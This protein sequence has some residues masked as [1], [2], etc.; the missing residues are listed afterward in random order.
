MRGGELA[1]LL[2]RIAQ[3]EGLQL[4]F[5]QRIDSARKIARTLAAFANTEGGS[6]L[7]GVKDNG[8][9][10]GVDPE[11]EYHMVDLAARRYVRPPVSFEARAYEVEGKAILEI[12][13]PP[14]PLDRP[15]YAVEEDGR[16][17]AYV[18]VADQTR[19][20]GEFLEELWKSEKRPQRI[21]FRKEEHILLEYLKAHPTISEATY[22]ALLGRRRAWKARKILI[23]YLIAGT[24][25]MELTPAGEVFRLS[26]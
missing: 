18:R 2:A 14:N 21:Y 26:A 9:I 23:K 12:Y 24:L 6:L 25:Q 22:R 8:R 20:A 7:I 11:Q 15:F 13:V 5:K 10:V 16:P 17:R 19:L 3:G 4:D 1:S